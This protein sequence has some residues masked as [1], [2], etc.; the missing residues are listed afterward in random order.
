MKFHQRRQI[1][2][3]NVISTRRHACDR[4]ARA[5]AGINRHIQLGFL[6]VALGDWGEKQSRRA[7]KAPVKLKLDGCDL[8]LSQT[9]TGEKGQSQG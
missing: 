9:L 6:E 3:A 4:A 2:K 7:F 8:G 1:G 5:I